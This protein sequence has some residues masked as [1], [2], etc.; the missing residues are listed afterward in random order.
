MRDLQDLDR[1]EAEARRHLALGVGGE[2]DVGLRRSSTTHDDGV[3]VR[4]LARESRVLGPEHADDSRPSLNESP[5]AR[6]DDRHGGARARA[7]ST[8]A[9]SGEADG[10]LGIDD[11]ADPQPAQHPA[12]PPMWSRWGCVSTS[13]ASDRRRSRAAGR[14]TSAS[15]GPSSTSI[16]AARVSTSTRRPDRR[17]GTITRSPAGGDHGGAWTQR[18]ADRRDRERRRRAAPTVAL[19]APVARQPT[20][21]DQPRAPRRRGRPGRRATRRG[22]R[23]S[24]RPPARPRRDPGRAPARQPRE[25]RSRVGEHRLEAGGR[26]R[27]RRSAAASRG[28]AAT[29]AGT[30]QSATAPKW[31]H[32]D[33]RG[34][35]AAGDGD[36]AHVPEPL[37]TG[38]ASGA[39][40][41]GQHDEDRRD[42]GKRE[43]EAGL[44]RGRRQ[45]GEQHERARPRARATGR[46][47]WRVEPRQRGE[48]AGDGGADD[49]RLPADR[50]R[51]GQHD[52]DRHRLAERGARSP[53]PRAPRRRRSRAISARSGPRRPGG[54]SSPRPRSRPAAP[55]RSP[56]PRRGRFRRR[57]AGAR[58]SPARQRALDVC[59][60]PVG[61]ATDPAPP[62]DDPPGRSP[63]RTTCTP[64]RASHPRSSKPVSGPRGAT[65]RAHSS[66][67]AP[68]GGARSG[69]SSSSTRSRIRVGAVPTD[70]GGHAEGERRAS[71]QGP[72]T[73]T[74][75]GA[76]SPRRRGEKLPVERR[77]RGA[78]P[79][80]ARRTR[81]R[82]LRARASP[83][84]ATRDRA[85]GQRR[86]RS[87]SGTSG[88][89]DAVTGGEPGARSRRR[90]ARGQFVA[91]ARRTAAPA[92]T[93]SPARGAAR[94][95][96]GRSRASRRGPR[97]TG[98]ARAPAASRRSSAR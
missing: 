3:L 72:V 60:Q 84:P 54:A 63:R 53:R 37:G 25:R 51:V 10:E 62:A 33:R 50:Q 67:T 48:H 16:D 35:A 22:R 43:L 27:Q 64:R 68:C 79:T 75:H 9:R 92:L 91:I 30:V 86:A 15:G 74:P 6:H 57:A 41:R 95:A 32:D 97:P 14:P 61:D 93:A 80:R 13:A 20:D 81:A 45:P 96:P 5:R 44:E 71:R 70:L 26:E 42:R 11:R 46:A 58:R 78:S 89:A 65:G 94:P 38:Y 90:A 87:P 88:R 24:R 1:A 29:L 49:R 17:R 77:R 39:R 36:G 55:G 52:A 40:E 76:D 31:S 85:A 2:E 18:A 4:V 21:T 98:T 59:A 69:G 56:S 19:R 23:A 47:A 34:H 66:S 7:E 82:R 8:A 83:R 28:P 12:A 73:T